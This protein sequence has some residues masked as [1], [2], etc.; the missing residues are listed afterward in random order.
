MNISGWP[1]FSTSPLIAAMRATR[2]P[3]G[4]TT[5]CSIF[6]ASRIATAW[7]ARTSSP[8]ATSMEP[9]VACR[10]ARDRRPRRPWS[11]PARRRRGRSRRRVVEGAGLAG[12]ARLDQGRGVVLD[13]AGGRLAGQHRRL[14]PAG[15]AAPRRWSPRPRCGTRPAPAPCAPPL[16]PGSGRARSPWPAGSRSW[17]WCGSRRS[18]SRRRARPGPTAARR[19]AGRRRPGARRRPRSGSPG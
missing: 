6:I 3:T 12:R 10:P 15:R 13:E 11:P 5:T 2:P 14:A 18:H 19:R 1:L 16:R 17:G 7:P 8:S 4:A 9:T